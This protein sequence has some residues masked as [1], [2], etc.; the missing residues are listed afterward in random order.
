MERC[1]I[2]QPSKNDPL[3][4]LHGTKVLAMP[5]TGGTRRC[6]FLEGKVISMEIPSSQLSLGWPKS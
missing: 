4:R 5:Y 2:N 3:H 6:Y 1:F